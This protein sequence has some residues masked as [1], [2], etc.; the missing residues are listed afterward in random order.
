MAFRVCEY[1][2]RRVT[3]LDIG[4]PSTEGNEKFDFS[5]LIDRR[6]VRMESVLACLPLGVIQKES[7]ICRMSSGAGTANQEPT[8]AEPA[9]SGQGRVVWWQPRRAE[10]FRLPQRAL[11]A[12][13]PHARR[14]EVRNRS[15]AETGA[16][17]PAPLDGRASRAAT[18]A[19]AAFQR[20]RGERDAA[21]GV[22]G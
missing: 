19:A 12:A 9:V 22:L 1:H 4:P 17:A 5:G 3:L 14:S 6:G 18:M 20:W 13:D 8:A 16:A 21:E 7:G 15:V 2:P 11:S 10:R